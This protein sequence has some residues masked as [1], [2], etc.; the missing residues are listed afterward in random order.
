LID[1]ANRSWSGIVVAAIS[2]RSVI[3]PGESMPDEKA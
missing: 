2:R 1:R 3:D